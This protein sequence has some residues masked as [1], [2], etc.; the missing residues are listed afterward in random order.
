MT[1]DG[2]IATLG[3]KV[4]P[5]AAHV[6]VDDVEVNLDPSV[7][8]YAL[9]KPSGVATTLR[10]PQGRP[11]I[12][13]T[14]P[15]RVRVCS[16]WDASTASPRD[17]CCSRTTRTGESADAPESSGGEGVPGRGRGRTHREADGARDRASSSTT[18]PPASCAPASSEPRRA[19]APCVWRTPRAASARCGACSRPSDSRSRG[20]SVYGVGPIRLGDLE[21]GA[22]RPL[23]REEIQA[24]AALA[25]VA[26]EPRPAVRRARAEG[27]G[28]TLMTVRNRG[29][30]R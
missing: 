3:D 19:G 7:R 11:D 2:D 28:A 17:C 16:L 9:H 20:S 14:C 10:D 26:C 30:S 18:A 22:V 1:V 8:Y 25:G 27:E 21:P 13:G 23:A 24:L 5:G 4:E 6:R 29:P 15:P 12:R